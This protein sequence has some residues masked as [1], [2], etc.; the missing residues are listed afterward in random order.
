M[1]L[2][3]THL[4]AAALM[5]AAVICPLCLDASRGTGSSSGEWLAPITPQYADADTARATLAI[6]GMTCASCATTARI[7]L[8]RS[9]GVYQATVSYDSASAVVHYDSERTSPPQFIATL[10]K[11]TGY[12]AAL[13]REQ[14]KAERS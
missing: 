12:D 14:S 13:V 8:E 5:G 9:E 1:V 3:S 11:L 7:A 10:K 4:A 6:E 2:S